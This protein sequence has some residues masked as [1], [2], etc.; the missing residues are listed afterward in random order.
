MKLTE[1]TVAIL[2]NFSTINNGLVIKKGNKQQTVSLTR[3]ILAEAVLDQKFPRDVPIYDLNGFLSL[4]STFDETGE[5]EIEFKDSFMNVKSGARRLKYF[6]AST[7][8]IF[9]PPE[10]L[11]LGAP[12]QR[13]TLPIDDLKLV[14]KMAAF[15]MGDMS[16][17][18]DGDKIDISVSNNDNSSSNEL[19]IAVDE[20]IDQCNVVFDVGLMK[21]IQ[22]EYSVG[23]AENS[24]HLK[25]AEGD[26]QYWI[27]VEA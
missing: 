13:F 4:L 5:A 22:Q 17:V 27:V 7:D 9:S 6:Y 25:N 18:S 10:G 12:T 1:R 2:K 16:I 14:Q 24:I 20:Q 8:V 15:G 21:V 23:V 11:D 3:D 19:S 26:T